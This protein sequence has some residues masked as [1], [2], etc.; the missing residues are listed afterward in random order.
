M[1][2]QANPALLPRSKTKQKELSIPGWLSHLSPTLIGFGRKRPASP[3][4]NWKREG[5]GG[6]KGVNRRGEVNIKS[7]F[8]RWRKTGTQTNGREVY[9]AFFYPDLQVLRSRNI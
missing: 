3:L 4:Y 5:F 6:S 8:C 1:Q 7:G 2:A 9:G